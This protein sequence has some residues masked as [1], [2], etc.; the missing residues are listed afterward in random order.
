[1]QPMT[2][3]S[4]TRMFCFA[5]PTAGCRSRKEGPAG[6]THLSC[7]E[8]SSLVSSSSHDSSHR[9]FDESSPLPSVCWAAASVWS[10]GQSAFASLVSAK[11]ASN[12][13]RYVSSSYRQRGSPRTRRPRRGRWSWGPASARRPGRRPRWACRGCLK[14]LFARSVRSGRTN[15]EGFSTGGAGRVGVVS[16]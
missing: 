11:P 2:E 7:C 4:V 1:M 16:I 13:E 3:S 5:I 15:E 6:Y 8:K 12:R 14:P 9:C 10:S